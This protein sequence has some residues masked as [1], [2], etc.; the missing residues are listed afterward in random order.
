MTFEDFDCGPTNYTEYLKLVCCF[1]RLATRVH[2]RRSRVFLLL[3]FSFEREKESG[4]GERETE[5]ER[6]RNYHVCSM[7]NLLPILS[8]HLIEAD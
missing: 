5:R 4:D 2:Q 7:C 3:H 1:D 8:T 6:K